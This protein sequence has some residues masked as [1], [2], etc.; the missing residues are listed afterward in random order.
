MQIYNLILGGFADS[1]FFKN[2]REKHSLCYYIS[3]NFS[4]YE[5]VL[6][7]RSGITKD[8]YDKIVDLIKK[9]MK[10]VVKGDFSNELLDEAKSTYKSMLIT[11]MDYPANLVNNYYDNQIDS[12]SLFKDRMDDIDKVS[13]E[14]IKKIASKVKMNTIFLFGGDSK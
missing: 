5:N 12:I 14:D 3:S 13:T 7:I 9:E 10:R 1:L 8:N 2:I 4:Y 11:A 6:Y